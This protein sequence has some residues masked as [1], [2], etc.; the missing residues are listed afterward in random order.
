M[1]WCFWKYKFYKVEFPFIFFIFYTL[2]CSLSQNK[3]GRQDVPFVVLG[4]ILLSGGWVTYHVEIMD[5][6]HCLSWSLLCIV[7]LWRKS[8]TQLYMVRYGK[9]CQHC[10]LPTQ[11]GAFV[12][13]RKSCATLLKI[14]LIFC[15]FNTFLKTAMQ[16]RKTWKAIVV[17]GQHSL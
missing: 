14:E 12:Q 5:Y 10:N 17:R 16:D 11:L 15:H 7:C 3:P 8:F 9:G 4:H 6:I 1:K 13:L 2:F